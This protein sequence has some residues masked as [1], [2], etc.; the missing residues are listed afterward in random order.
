MDERALT[1]AERR[2]LSPGLVSA[3]DAAGVE[4]L[5][6]PRAAWAAQI[7]RLW[8]GHVPVLTRGRRI[9]WP[10][11][12]ADLSA[13]PAAM[14]LVQHELQHVLDFATG[15]LSAFGYLLDPRNWI[16]RLPA[17]ELWDW[18]RLGAEQR[19]VLAE[20]LWRAEHGDDDPHAEACR[21]VIPWAIDSAAQL[22]G[23]LRRQ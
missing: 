4:P 16:Y 8:R 14:A 20:K 15:R 13:H 23:E 2:M 22:A 3:L 12:P 5:I 7:A 9:Y 21:H 10:G 1:D 11:A 19:A 17:P 6:A 18:G